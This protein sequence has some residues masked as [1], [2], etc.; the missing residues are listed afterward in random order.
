MPPQI[1]AGEERIAFQLLHLV[2]I[3]ELGIEPQFVKSMFAC[4]AAAK[5]PY[6]RSKDL[7]TTTVEE[8]W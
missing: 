7:E 4:V 1:P 2:W 5:C 3:L 6:A 8:V